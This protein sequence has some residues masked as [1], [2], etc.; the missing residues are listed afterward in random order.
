MVCIIDKEWIK[1]QEIKKDNFGLKEETKRN[2]HTEKSS[3][4]NTRLGKALETIRLSSLKGDDTIYLVVE[5]HPL[6]KKP[7][8]YYGHLVNKAGSLRKF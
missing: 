4:S 5:E 1:L 8:Y 7:E 3:F 6:I 2:Y